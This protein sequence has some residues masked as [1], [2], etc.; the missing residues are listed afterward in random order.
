MSSD[1]VLDP[2]FWSRPTANRHGD[3]DVDD[4]YVAVGRA[5]SE[6][7]MVEIALGRL[8]AALD[9]AAPHTAWSVYAS[10]RDPRARHARL[11]AAAQM[12]FADGESEDSATCRRLIEACGHAA[13]RRDDVVHGIAVLFR[14]GALDGS[15]LV[16]TGFTAGDSNVPEYA[17]T[18]AQITTL[19]GRFARLQ[20]E[21]NVLILR[22][23]VAGGS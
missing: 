1:D 6:W 4:I 2:R 22:L 14:P 18:A 15:Y 20:D 13:Q 23:Q 16:P 17:Y 7:S 5:L 11:G 19:R 3:I 10:D 12:R 21:I 8:Y 9:G